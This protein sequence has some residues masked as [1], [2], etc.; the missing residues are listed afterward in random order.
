[1]NFKKWVKS[2]QIVGYNG[3]RMVYTIWTSLSAMVPHLSNKR[4]GLNKWEGLAEFFHLYITAIGKVDF[5]SFIM[6]KTAGV[7]WIFFL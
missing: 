7:V 2:V 3:A 6:W 1:M 4:S 5:F